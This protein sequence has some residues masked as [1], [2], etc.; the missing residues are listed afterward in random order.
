MTGSW[1]PERPSPSIPA[2][3]AMPRPVHGAIGRYPPDPLNPHNPEPD[4]ALKPGLA[5]RSA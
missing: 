5:E 3:C 2:R 4:D 1:R